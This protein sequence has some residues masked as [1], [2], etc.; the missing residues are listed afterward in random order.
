M[1][2]RWLSFAGRSAP[3]DVWPGDSAECLSLDKSSKVVAR[4]RRRR[5]YPNWDIAAGC[6]IERKEGLILVEAKA[7]V[8][9]LSVLGK[10]LDPNASTASTDNHEQIAAAIDDACSALR[11]LGVAT[12]ISRDSHYQ[13]SNRVAFT[14]KLAALGIPTV[15][16]YLGFTDDEGVAGAGLPF[17]NHSH[18]ETVFGE[19]AYSVVPRTIFEQRIDCGAAAVWFLASLGPGDRDVISAPSEYSDIALTL[20]TGS[21]SSPATMTAWNSAGF[22]PDCLQRKSPTG[23]MTREHPQFGRSV[24][25]LGPWD[26]IP[27]DELQELVG[28]AAGGERNH[29]ALSSE[30]GP[31]YIQRNW[32]VAPRLLKLPLGIGQVQQRVTLGPAAIVGGEGHE[33]RS[34]L[35]Q[36]FGME[37]D[38][39]ASR[40][41]R[42]CVG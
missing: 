29:T 22:S 15:L 42:R 37:R 17:S 19:Y 21:M 28:I 9:E 34:I 3:G 32:A 7:N 18:W 4:S 10:S 2:A 27:G 24:G 13:L 6:E 12:T 16:V 14:W 25:F 5:E 41:N 11:Q 39:L 33:N 1:D 40:N 35:T 30:I 31:R 23:P 8:P 38:L 20:R 36:Y 26:Q